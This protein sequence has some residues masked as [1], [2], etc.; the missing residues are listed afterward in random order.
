MSY[1]YKQLRA[2]AFRAA[3]LSTLI[4]AVSLVAG[5]TSMGVQAVKDQSNFSTFRVGTT[6][7]ADVYTKLGQPDDVITFLGRNGWRY[8]SADTMLD[9]A[10][11]VLGMIIP[12]LMLA[13]PTSFD[14]TQADFYFDDGGKLLDTTV[15]KS[16]TSKMITSA[17]EAYTDKQKEAVERVKKEMGEIQKPFDVE[18]GKKSLAYLAI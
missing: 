12:V 6:T 15:R 10:M 11:T 8:V 9:P 5:C 2:I 18:I 7:K 14:I 1:E 3:R 13:A 17:G 4:L 16:Q